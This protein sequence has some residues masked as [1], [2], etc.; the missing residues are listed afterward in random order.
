V[1]WTSFTPRQQQQ[2]PIAANDINHFFRHFPPFFAPVSL[3][4]CL[5]ALKSV[6]QIVKTSTRLFAVVA[7]VVGGSV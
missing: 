6:L 4:L 2:K 1:R 5:F 7:I 3:W